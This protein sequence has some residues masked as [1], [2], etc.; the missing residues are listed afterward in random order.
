M[1]HDNIISTMF[2]SDIVSLRNKFIGNCFF[3]LHSRSIHL[4]YRII[5]EED[6]FDVYFRFGSNLILRFDVDDLAQMTKHQFPTRALL[7]IYFS[8]SLLSRA[9]ESTFSLPPTFLAHASISVGCV[10][11]DPTQIRDRFSKL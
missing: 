9:N 7:I 3:F 1:E 10:K 5:K 8:L 4:V 6:G 2:W 11:Y